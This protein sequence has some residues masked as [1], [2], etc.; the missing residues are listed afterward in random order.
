MAT[1][2][3]N[4]RTAVR[5]ELRDP[6]GV[7][8]QDP[9]VNHAI[10]MAY[11]RVYMRIAR[12]VQD[13]FVTTSSSNVV[14]GTRAYALPSDCLRLKS[15]E[16]VK[17]NVTAPLTR[18]VRGVG[19]NYT[20]AGSTTVLIVPPFT[21]DFEGDNIVLEPTPQESVTNG[22]KFTYYQT[23]TS[24]SSDA[25][26]INS[27]FKDTWIDAIVLDAT[28]NCLSQIEAEGA[29]VSSTIKE[30]LKNCHE[31]I[32]A[33]IRLRTLSPRRRSRRGFFQ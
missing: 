26:T 4:L 31:E 23:S 28:I 25:S 12:Y 32:D 24:L 13:Y 5:I 11:R 9:D 10:N 21:F 30:R 22:L 17:S 14:S 16:Y 15:L 19:L 18:Y 6:D 27:N 33:F 1:T 2:L 7:T 8:F 3:L 20:G 29:I